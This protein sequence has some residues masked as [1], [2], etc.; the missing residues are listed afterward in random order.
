MLGHF[1]NYFL[2]L[3]KRPYF[4]DLTA[5]LTKPLCSVK[6]SFQS[7]IYV[8]PYPSLKTILFVLMKWQVDKMTQHLGRHTTGQDHFYLANEH[9]F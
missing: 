4:P 9:V 8:A 2:H 6:A 7:P 5:E 3:L 1:I